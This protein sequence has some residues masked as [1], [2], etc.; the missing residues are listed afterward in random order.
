MA[1]YKVT[2]MSCAACSARVEKAV[3]SLPDVDECSVNLLTGDMT[4]TGGASSDEVITAVKK[5]GYGAYQ[6]DAGAKPAQ[7]KEQ[8]SETKTLLRRFIISLCILAPLMYVSMGHMMFGW[9]LPPFMADNH[10]AMGLVQ[11]IL[12]AA[13]MVINKKFFVSGVSG[14]FHGAPN[15]DTLVSLGSGASFIYSTVML[16]I[17]TDAVMKGDPERVMSC[18][19][20]LYFEGAAMILALITLGKMLEAYSKGKTTN[21]LKGLSKL[22]PDTAHIIKDGKEETVSVK[23]LKVGDIF[24]VYPGEKIPTDAVITEGACSVDESSLTGESVPVDKRE[25]DRV[26][27]A[28]M[29]KTG[30]V[31]CR[32]EAVGEDT[33]LSRIMKAVSDAAASKAPIA[34]AAD[35][36]SG[37]FVPVIMVIALITTVIW[38]IIGRGA[39]FALARG[40]SVLVISCPCALGLATPVA[41]MVGSGVGARNNILFKTAAALE[42]TGKVKTVVF[43]KT[44]T[45]TKGRPHVTDII[46]YSTDKDALLRLSASL[47]SK[48]EHPFAY[49]ITEAADKKNIQ[50]FDCTDF[51]N[52]PGKGLHGIINGRQ[53]HGGNVLYISGFCEI[54]ENAKDKAIQLS[55][56]GKTPLYF[57]YDGSFIGMIAAADEIKEDSAYAVSELK[58]LGIDTVMLTGDNARTANAVGKMLGIN[59]V[60]A[61]VLPEQKE[62][63]IKELCQKNKTAMVGDGINDAPALTAADIGIAIGTGTDIAVDSAEVVLMKSSAADAATAIRLSKKTLKNIYENLFWAFIYN[64][65][66]IPIAAG[67][68]AGLGITLNPMIASAA[69]SLSSFC[70]VCNALRLNLFKANKYTENIPEKEIPDKETKEMKKTMFIEGMMCPHCEARVKKTLEMI[71]GVDTADVSHEKG[72]AAVTLSK[73][74]SDEKLKVAVEEQGYTVKGIE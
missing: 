56:E 42:Q 3:S 21:A 14:L 54:P 25:D 7:D 64:A 32:A 65:V 10:V 62:A 51:E 57:E 26:S 72:T 44:G 2:G 52:I 1:K 69:M 48:S 18:M 66:C 9:P 60:E 53:A 11:M 68:F 8:D 24:A 30:F 55:D 71:D 22:M 36:V 58:K 46:P 41:V 67:A 33:A 35:K 15:M 49:A 34:K 61:G 63:V 40:I 70:V 5:A 43:D 39:G 12:A 47:E 45:L 17:M 6:A 28:T 23:E 4:V 73:E 37:V 29:N 16:F 59:R 74:I 31:K 13:V 38:L 20:E 19:N 27:G 50:S